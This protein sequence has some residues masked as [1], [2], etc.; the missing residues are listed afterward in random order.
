MEQEKLHRFH[1]ALMVFNTQSGVIVFTL[2]RLTA[3]YFGT[4]GW[5]ALFPVF[6]FVT[7]NIM[8]I[9]AVH[10]LGGGRSVFDILQSSLPRL[11]LYPLYLLL[12]GIFSMIGCLVVKQYVLIYQLLIFPSTSDMLLKFFVDLL[13]FLYVAKGIYTMSKANVLFS[14][15]LLSLLPLAIYFTQEF[16][17][18]RLTSFMFEGGTDMKEGFLRV[19]GAY[20]GY[21]LTLFLF[22]YAEP[23]KK[24]L[25]YIHLGNGITMAIYL[26]ATILGFGF[27]NVQELSHL[28]FPLLDMFSYIR[29]PFVERLQN[30]LYS[31]FLF[32]ILHTA[33]MYY[34]ASQSVLSR[35][36]RRI[37]WKLLVFCTMVITIFTASIPETLIKVEGWF[38]LFSIF[39]LGFSV[40]FP[41]LLIILLL[42]QR[43]SK[44][45]A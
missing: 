36:F 7:L 41:L 6:L 31:V 17:L 21:E 23:G 26:L 20:M 37:P 4:N 5:L 45:H 28:A 16:D 33:A 25:K 44:K 32:S 34:W 27:F 24:W 8:L 1:I 19:Y 38:R 3:H 35:I 22:P 40:A 42:F 43:R 15:F 12:W 29:F 13:V 39:Q 30:F 2:P 18:V 14:F 11:I 9:S 10:R